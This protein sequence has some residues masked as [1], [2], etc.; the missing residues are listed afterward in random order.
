MQ[1][2]RTAV[3]AV[4]VLSMSSAAWKA[5]AAEAFPTRPIRLIVPV[6]PGGGADF[7]ARGYAARLTESLGQQVVVDNRAGGNGNIGM[8]IAAKDRSRCETWRRRRSLR[9]RAR[10]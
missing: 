9:G 6:P 8:D 3:A 1:L 2:L 4:C 7:V 5:A 10:T